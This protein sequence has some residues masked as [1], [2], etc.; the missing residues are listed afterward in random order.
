MFEILLIIVIWSVI[1]L[2]VFPLEKIGVYQSKVKDQL[3]KFQDKM[4]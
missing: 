1:A 3:K 4:K 2:L